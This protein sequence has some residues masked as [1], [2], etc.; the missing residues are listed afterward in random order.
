MPRWTP[1]ARLKHAAAIRGWMPWTLSTG[2]VTAEGK[3]R[4]SRNAWKGGVRPLVSN[5]HGTLRQIALITERLY[6]SIRPKRNIG[7]RSAPVPAGTVWNA[8]KDWEDDLDDDEELDAIDKMS[9]AEV[10]EALRKIM[11]SRQAP[12]FA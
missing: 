4:S 10:Q 2:P 5:W 6:S 9:S 8:A 11:A 3:R 7:P 12:G 1:E